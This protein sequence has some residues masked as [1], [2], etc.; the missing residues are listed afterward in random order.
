MDDQTTP[1]E[2]I[3]VGGPNGPGKTTFAREYLAARPCMYLSA[4]EIAIELSSSDPASARRRPGESFYFALNGS[5]ANRKACLSKQRF[6]EKRLFA[7]GS[8]P[9]PKA[10]RF[11]PCLSFSMDRKHVSPG[12]KSVF[13]KAA[14]MFPRKTFAGGWGRRTSS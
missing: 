1:K 5:L 14:R 4:D 9:A 12:S 7:P 3:V 8:L 10:L 6:Q 2:I 13:V 11:G